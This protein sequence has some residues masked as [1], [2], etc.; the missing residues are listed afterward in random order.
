MRHRLLGEQVRGAHE[1]ADGRPA[2]GQR[3][4]E[5]GHHRRRPLVVHPAREEHLDVGGVITAQEVLQDRELGLP[6][7]EAAARPDMSAALGALEHETAR[8][9]LKELPQQPR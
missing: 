5:R 8:P 7:R 6:Q 4:G 9:G 2:R 3:R 1:H